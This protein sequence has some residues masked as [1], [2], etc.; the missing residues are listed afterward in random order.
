MCFCLHVASQPA[1]EFLTRA[2]VSLGLDCWRGEVKTANLLC[3]ASLGTD[4]V[5]WK[6]KQSV[7][8]I[9]GQRG[10]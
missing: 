2:P 3:M 5:R 10:K 9:V 7:A 1:K 8:L 6:L 4:A